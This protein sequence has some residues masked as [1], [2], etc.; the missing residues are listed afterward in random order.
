MSLRF[1]KWHCPCMAAVSSIRIHD[2]VSDNTVI[3]PEDRPGWERF[4]Y[5]MVWWNVTSADFEGPAGNPDRHS[6]TEGGVFNLC[7]FPPQEHKCKLRFVTVF[8]QVYMAFCTLFDS[9]THLFSHF[10]CIWTLGNKNYHR[11]FVDKNVQEKWS[12]LLKVK[13]LMS[14]RDLV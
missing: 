9:A 1:L 2:G 14:A 10:I 11:H 8:E 12:T 7:F 4:L 3:S 6:H 5:K 13:W